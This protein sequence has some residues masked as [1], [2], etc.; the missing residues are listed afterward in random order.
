MGAWGKLHPT[1]YSSPCTTQHAEWPAYR[2]DVPYQWQ[3]APLW[4]RA[5]RLVT[6]SNDVAPN[7]NRAQQV[8]CRDPVILSHARWKLETLTLSV[9]VH[10]NPGHPNTTTLHALTLNRGDPHLSRRRWGRLLQE[11][12]ASSPHIIALQEVRFKTGEAHLAYTAKACPNY[13][14]LAHDDKCPDMM[15]LVHERVHKYCKLMA[16]RSPHAIALRVQLPGV[17]KFTFVNQ[18]GPFTLREREALDAW[19]ASVPS[20]GILGGDF[21]DGIWHA[22]PRRSRIWYDWLDTG[23]LIDPQYQTVPQP[24]GPSHTRGGK[25]LDSL[26]LSQTTWNAL[27]PVAYQATTFPSAGYHTGVEI[28][29]TVVLPEPQSPHQE[30]ISIREW[31]GRDL[32]RFRAHMGRCYRGIPKNMTMETASSMVLKGIARYVAAHKKPDRRPDQTHQDLPTRL[33]LNL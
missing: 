29:T 4:D 13:K 3:A 26:L 21:N 22:S 20:V 18:H 11:I 27:T 16:H 25:R 5:Q 19:I 12:T 30:V 32:K 2:D 33:A 9:D 28:H 24:Q 14:P 23:R 31:T 8:C 15:F 1:E 7:P 17:P 6:L 10:P